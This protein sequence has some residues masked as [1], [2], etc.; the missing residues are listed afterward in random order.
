MV[1]TPNNTEYVGVQVWT[2]L[3]VLVIVYM[4]EQIIH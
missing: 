2:Y 3:K 1:G 4:N